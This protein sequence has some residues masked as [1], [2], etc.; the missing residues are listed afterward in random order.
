M[1]DGTID[2]MTGL[3][4][5]A[6]LLAGVPAGAADAQRQAEVARRGAQV[7]PFDLKATLHVFTK[8]A[9]GGIQRVVARDPADADQVR[10]VR[11]HLRQIQGEFQRG[12]FSAPEQI[13][14]HEMPGLAVLRAADPGAID[15]GYTDVAA[16]AELAYRA[17]DPRLVDA[18]HAWFDA[19]LDDHGADAMAGHMHHHGAGMTP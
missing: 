11:E 5:A 19:Q 17:R 2:I 18:L 10:R 15:I 9:S 3:A 14:G 13:H 7:M 12:D 16:G 8:T 6:L 1:R 4:A